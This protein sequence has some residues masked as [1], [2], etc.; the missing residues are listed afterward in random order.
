MI[1]GTAAYM[2]PE[3]AQGKET[4][5]RTDIFALGCVLFEMLTGR[6]TFPGDSAAQILARVIERE[7]DWNLLPA[8]TPTAIRRL[9]QRCLQK[10]RNRRLKSADTIRIEIEEVL[11]RPEM[12]EVAPAPPMPVR[13]GLPWIIAATL[14]AAIA[15][16][17]VPAVRHL[18]ESAPAEF[19]EL[20]TDI[21]TPTTT[22]P[23]SFALSP[24]G[25]QIVFAASGNGQQRLWLRQLNQTTAQ[26]LAGTE[27]A[28][29]PFWAPDSQSIGF[30]DST[31]M[32]R[33]DISGGAARILAE[34]AANR[35]GTWNTDGV[36]LFSRN[37][38]SPLFRVGAIGGM[39]V[40]VTNSTNRPAIATPTFCRTVITSF[41][42]RLVLLK[43]VA[44]I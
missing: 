4:D 15:V 26:P 20:R 31:R 22:E 42:M 27:G 2:S 14:V 23:A 1:L 33:V 11:A 28:T 24:D 40:A 37:T 34:N 10:D 6:Q 19:F 44:S 21:V 36:I 13:R 35:G 16:L 43:R 29:Y 30:F 8:S 41:F 7:P 17:S 9:L 32:K 12:V 39:P 5:R 3:Q 18:R 38:A 25:R